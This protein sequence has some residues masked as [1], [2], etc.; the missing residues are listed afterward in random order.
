[1]NHLQ[2]VLSYL[3]LLIVAFLAIYARISSSKYMYHWALMLFEVFIYLLTCIMAT[4]FQCAWY[5]WKHA[6]TFEELLSFA[7]IVTVLH[8]LG[9]FIAARILK[10]IKWL[11]AE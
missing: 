9:T 7:V 11:M 5:A 4:F 1:M 6:R 3:L 10:K 8:L 2:G